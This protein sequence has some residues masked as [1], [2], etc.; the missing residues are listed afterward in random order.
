MALLYNTE[1]ELSKSETLGSEPIAIFSYTMENP[2]SESHATSW[3]KSTDIVPRRVTT[4]EL[5]NPNRSLNNYPSCSDQGTQAFTINK[6]T[7]RSPVQSWTTKKLQSARCATGSRAKQSVQHSTP[8]SIREAGLHSK[9]SGRY[10]RRIA[11]DRAKFKSSKTLGMVACK[12]C[13]QLK[14]P[15]CECIYAHQQCD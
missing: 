4:V 7:S 12:R 8:K 13:A 9:N 10:S 2:G 3:F 14:R 1:L 15:V 6:L 11:D 5:L